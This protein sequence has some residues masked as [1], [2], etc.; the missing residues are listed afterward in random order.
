MFF[1]VMFTLCAVGISLIGLVILGKF[2]MN[3]YPV[4]M[5][6]TLFLVF[7]INA[8]QLHSNAIAYQYITESIFTFTT[9]VCLVS[10][11]SVLAGWCYPNIRPKGFTSISQNHSQTHPPYYFPYDRLF[12]IGTVC[13][14]IS[15][16]AELLIASGRGGLIAL[17]S[18]PHN[19]Y[20]GDDNPILFYLFFLTFVGAVPYLQC[21]FCNKALPK[22]QRLIILIVCALQV[23]RTIIVGQRGWVFNLVFIYLTVPFFCMGTLPKV[24]QVAYFLLPAAL[25]VIIIPAIRGNIYLGSTNLDRL[26]SLVIEALSSAKEGNTGSGIADSTDRSRVSSE[27]IIGAATISAAWETNSYTHGLSFYDSLINPIPRAI[28]KEKP[29]NI[30]LQSQIA[31]INNNYPWRFN[32]GSAPTGIADVFLNFG[33]FCI[34][35]WFFFGLIH[36]WV[37]DIA[38][39]PGNFYAQGIYATLLWGSTFL[40]NQGVLLWGTT[41]MSSTFFM[42][43]FYS[44]ARLVKSRSLSQSP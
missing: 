18:R 2:P 8:L 21:L 12:T 6:P 34:P 5:M 26:P 13:H 17:Y 31:I 32:D 44:Y 3:A 19:F 38:S 40:L 29:K 20:T 33:F 9:F 41:I 1:I 43:L 16:L 22:Y 35:F 10:F 25:F 23:C 39:V 37:Y 30:G 11:L 36:R 42:T 24:R 7:V 28:W 27:F 4:L 14:I 15:F